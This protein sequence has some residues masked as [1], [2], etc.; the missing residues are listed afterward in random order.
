M[1]PSSSLLTT[2]HCSGRALAEGLLHLLYPNLCWVCAAPI[3][4][5]G[6]SF[7]EACQSALTLD[8]LSTCPRCAATVG[9]FALTAKG[10]PLCKDEAFAFERVIRLGKYDG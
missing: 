8:Y 4:E 1:P 7:C 6:R 3:T 9:P 5:P 10:C 2:L